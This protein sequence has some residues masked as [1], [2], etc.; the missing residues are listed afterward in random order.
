MAIAEVLIWGITVYG[1]IG[2]VTAAAFLLVGIDRIDE[3]AR[4]SYAFRP[5]LI[6]GILVLWPVVLLRWL[7]LERKE[8]EPRDL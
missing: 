2:A 3:D 8:P 1:V 4:G 7:E 6:P 5:L